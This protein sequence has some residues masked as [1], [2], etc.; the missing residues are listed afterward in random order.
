MSETQVQNEAEKNAS[1]VSVKQMVVQGFFWVFLAGIIVNVTQFVI[2]ILLARLLAPSDFG[3]VAIALSILN[4]IS[5]FQDLGLGTALI[6]RKKDVEESFNSVFVFVVAFGIFL[7]VLLVIFSSSLATYFND[8]RLVKVILLLAI[9]LPSGAVS[10][11]YASYVSKN[12]L[13]YHKFIAITVSLLCGSLL[14]LVLAVYGYGYISL[15][16]GYLTGAVLYTLLLVILTKWKPK[17]RFDL[18]VFKQL[19]NYGKYVLFA[20]FMAIFL[21]QGDNFVVSKILGSVQLGYYTMAYSLATL[22]AVNIAHA[23]STVVFPTFAKLQDNTQI[24]AS[25]FIKSMTLINNIVFPVSIG[26]V[27]ISPF[28]FNNLIGEKWLPAQSSFIILSFLALI[29]SLTVMPSYFL[30]GTGGSRTDFRIISLGIF[31]MVLFILPAVYNFGIVGVSIVMFVAYAFAFTNYLVKSAKKMCVAPQK[32]GKSFLPAVIASFFMVV[33]G[34]FARDILFGKTH[35]I[36]NLIIIV[37][38]CSTTYI[39]VLFCAD[40]KLFVDVK[41]LFSLLFDRN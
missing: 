25:G 31:V 29:K 22:P 23:I 16:F 8:E 1:I 40:R 4:S 6:Q 3:V 41:I 35:T 14:S 20:N 12:L 24:L 27:V 15:V 17:F 28:I 11:P 36:F 38:L 5:L 13:F 18:V 9:T 21:S 39:F 19:V 30:Q 2:K 26:A 7:S 34:V 32:I 33:V 37:L 10:I